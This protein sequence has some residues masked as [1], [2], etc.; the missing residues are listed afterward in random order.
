MYENIDVQRELAE[1]IAQRGST[2]YTKIQKRSSGLNAIIL[3]S[4]ALLLA[5]VNFNNF[6]DFYITEFSRLTGNYETIH[7][8]VLKL[9]YKEDLKFELTVKSDQNKVYVLKHKDYRYLEYMINIAGYKFD[10]L[11][12]ITCSPPCSV[13]EKGDPIIIKMDKAHPSYAYFYR[14]IWIDL[15][16]DHLLSPWQILALFF[17]FFLYFGY[18]STRNWLRFKILKA[19]DH[20]V[21]VKL[22]KKFNMS[23]SRY[24]QLYAPFFELSLRDEPTIYFRYKF[25]E[26]DQKNE[27]LNLKMHYHEI[28]AKLYMYNVN[29]PR[30]QRYFIE[31][32][33]IYEP[34]KD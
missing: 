13:I 24:D 21:Y 3:L 6:K 19:K 23:K 4:I 33:D 27:L 2:T 32:L 12:D 11:Q 31:I 22:S 17:P 1:Q 15:I 18:F 5:F 8:T 29:N 7:G 25:L 14:N 10:Q 20:F 9:A 28:Y 26:I 16:L 34:I 30:D